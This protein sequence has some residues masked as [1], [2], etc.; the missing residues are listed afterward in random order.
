M[1]PRSR[2]LRPVPDVETRLVGRSI[3]GYNRA[4][5]IAG[6]GPALLL[7]HGIGDSSAAWADLIP[8]LA[9][10]YTVIAPDLLGHGQSDKPRGDYS[11]AAYANGMRD[12]LAVLGIERATVVGHS[13]GGAVAMQMAYQFP[14]LVERLVLV[15]SSGI[16]KDVHPLLR[17]IA[18]PVA[19]EWMGMLKLPGGH[20]IARLAWNLL[21]QVQEGALSPAAV[22]SSTPDIMR[23]LGEL[24]DHAAYMAF[25][26]SLRSV[27]DWRGQVVTLL[28][29]VYLNEAMPVQ[30]VWGGRDTIFPVS[31]AHL[32]HSAMPGSRIAI[33]KR[34][35]HYPFRTESMGFLRVLEEFLES[36]VPAEFDAGRWRRTLLSGVG[37]EDIVGGPLTRMAVLDAMGSSERSAT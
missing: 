6:E 3:H 13:L 12:L 30:I 35:G 34:A 4:Y 1:T 10:H 27:V 5:R 26:Q 8:H 20:D 25:L 28:D 18:V 17:L 9:R 24:R 11:V 15:S 19:N 33:F 23:V 32:A 22:I 36:T 31:H 29:R 2:T 7:I 16:T 37:E 14:Q 21:D